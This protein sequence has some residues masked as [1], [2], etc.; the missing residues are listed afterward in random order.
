MVTAG[1]IRKGT[2]FVLDSQVYTVIEFLHVKP[3]KGAAF[4]RTK[5][6]NVINGNVVEKTFNPNEKF[7]DANIETR[8]MQYLYKEDNL[9]TFMDNETYEQVAVDEATVGD[10]VLYMEEDM[11]VTVRFFNGSAFAVQ[12]PNFVI[13]EITETEPGVR[14]DTASSG[15]TKPAKIKTGATVLVPLFVN[16]GDKIRI[17]TRT[18]EY[19][20]RA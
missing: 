15:G 19:M 11:N 16:Q 5:L 20:E 9:Y 18:G 3:G 14:G 12:V 2:T 1:D 10:S 8:D 6:K 7:E 4:V 13:F 17:D